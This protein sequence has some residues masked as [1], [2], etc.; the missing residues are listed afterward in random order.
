MSANAITGNTDRAMAVFED[1][2]KA[3]R[4]VTSLPCLTDLLWAL[5]ASEKRDEARRVVDVVLEYKTK[6]RDWEGES[7]DN[8][9]WKHHFWFLAEERG[10][11]EGKEVP[12]VLRASLRG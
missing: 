1:L 8:R 4:P 10:L 2:Q 7:K 3:R 9:Y 12:D 5:L 6:D 11:L